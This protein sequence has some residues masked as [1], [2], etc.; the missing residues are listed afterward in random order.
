MRSNYEVADPDE[1]EDPPE[2]EPVEPLELLP[3][4]LA[5]A[6]DP[7]LEPPESEPEPEPPEPDPPL[8]ESVR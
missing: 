1:A 8:R 4:L 6:P 2:D 3:E 7:E 5:A